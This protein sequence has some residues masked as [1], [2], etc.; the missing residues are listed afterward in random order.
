MDLSSLIA[1]VGMAAAVILPLFNIPLI[2]KIVQRKSSRDISLVWVVGVWICIV[3]MA[4]SGFISKD[5]VWR[6]FNYV[7][8]LLFTGVM[9]T[10][11]KYR[12]G[13]SEQ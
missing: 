2:L 11:L 5:M 8:I 6:T 4:P 13:R 10:T 7:N 1:S 9:I 12:H 3:L